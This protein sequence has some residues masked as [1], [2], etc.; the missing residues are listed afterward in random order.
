M[1]LVLRL[2][3]MR[4]ASE[5]CIYRPSK[6]IVSLCRCADPAYRVL[7]LVPICPFLSLFLL[8][9]SIKKVSERER[10]EQTKKTIAYMKGLTSA[11]YTSSLC[12]QS[13]DLWRR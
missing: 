3:H 6:T 9:A 10:S 11:L 4:L 1:M 13:R 5:H 2:A 8:V 12:S 7:L